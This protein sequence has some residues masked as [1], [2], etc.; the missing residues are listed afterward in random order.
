MSLFNILQ[1]GVM[2]VMGIECR[3]SNA[4]DAG[5]Q[6]IPRHWARF[7]EEAVIDRIP[8][9]AS[10]EVIALYCDYEG[11]AAQPYSLV[12]GCPVLHVDKIPEGMVVKEIP[13][14]SY[15]VFNAKGDFPQSLIDTWIA[16]WQREDLIRTYR[17]DFEVYGDKFF[18]Q[19]PQEVNVWVGI[20]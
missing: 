2:L 5:P 1:H 19:S 16:I 20:E 14:G 3:T 6:D 11:D 13:A 18:N 10:T 4:P 17:A 15:A 9:K 8:H 7:Y 12:I